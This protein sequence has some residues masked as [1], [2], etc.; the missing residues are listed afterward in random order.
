MKL[1]THKKDLNHYGTE[2]WGAAKLQRGNKNSVNKAHAQSHARTQ[3]HWYYK[4]SQFMSYEEINLN[5]FEMLHYIRVG[6]TVEGFR[7]KREFCTVKLLRQRAWWQTLQWRIGWMYWEIVEKW[8]I[9]DVAVAGSRCKKKKKK[10]V[11]WHWETAATDSVLWGNA[12]VY[13]KQ[14]TLE[15]G[16]TEGTASGQVRGRNVQTL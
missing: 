12:K 5:E 11:A 3:T 15:M 2:L 16:W 4:N 10:P 14:I 1:K 8:K 13:A 6:W 9:F 7:I